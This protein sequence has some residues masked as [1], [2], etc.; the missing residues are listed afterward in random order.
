MKL[1]TS[2]FDFDGVIAN[3]EP[4]YDQF[5][6]KAP[7][8][9]G[10][11]ITE[12]AHKIK[13]LTLMNILDSYFRTSSEQI[14]KQVWDD[15]MTFEKQMDFPPVK[16]VLSFLRLLKGQGVKIAI[17]TSSGQEKMNH[18][19]EVMKL[20]GLYDLL[21]TGDQI[22]KGKPAPDCFLLAAKKLESEPEDCVVFE[23]SYNGIKAGLAAQMRVVGLSTSNPEEKL[24]KYTDLV[25]P[26]FDDFTIEQYAQL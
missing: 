17:V 5:W 16:G 25:I 11:G 24:K 23:D 12:M 13:G 10:L 6:N 3:T 26:D 18:V 1:K 9:Y 22:K 8:R 19:F 15:C 21:V 2:L 14:R 7:L 20:E 4:L